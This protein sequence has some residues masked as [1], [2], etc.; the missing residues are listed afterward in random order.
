MH[1]DGVGVAKAR[2]ETVFSI[3]SQDAIEDSDRNTNNVKNP[4]GID[5]SNDILNCASQGQSGSHRW[6][7]RQ[8]MVLD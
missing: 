3:K 1:M 5:G 8:K 2:T 4:K 6:R 7:S